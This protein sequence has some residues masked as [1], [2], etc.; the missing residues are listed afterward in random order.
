MYLFGRGLK[1]LF[2]NLFLKL[3]WRVLENILESTWLKKIMVFWAMWKPWMEWL[4]RCLMV[5]ANYMIYCSTWNNTLTFL[6][7]Q[8]CTVHYRSLW[9]DFNDL[10]FGVM[11][12][13]QFI[14]RRTLWELWGHSRKWKNNIILKAI[15]WF[16]F[17]GL[18]SWNTTPA[19]QQAAISWS[20]DDWAISL[21]V[22]MT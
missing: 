18:A 14:R 15:D 8:R 4:K 11:N 22:D 3:S 12:V 19:P 10:S 6:T 17:V 16:G 2:N 5:H 1:Q 21:C 9:K 20:W 13:F 7:D